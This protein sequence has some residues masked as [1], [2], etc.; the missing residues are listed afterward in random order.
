MRKC[1]CVVSL[2][3]ILM[4][5]TSALAAVPQP[6]TAA[7]APALTRGEFAA[8]LVKAAE[9]EGDGEP[10]EILVQHGIMKGVPGKG[11]D[12]LRP[13]SRV[14]A[15]A[16]VARTL[17]LADATFPPDNT[18]IPLLPDHWA[19][20][21]YAWLAR[22]G[23]VSGDPFAVLSEEEGTS[24]V[25]NTF[26]TTEDVI[27]ILQKSQAQLQAKE[28]TSFRTVMDGQIR[29]TPRPGVEGA[30][31]IPSI[32]PKLHLVQEM[33]LP[34][35]IH[36]V[37]TVQMT[38]PEIGAQEMVTESYIVDGTMYQKLPD[39]ETGELSWVKYPQA[40][41]PDMQQL[42]EQ[43]QQQTQI[44]PPGMEKSLFYKLLGTKEIDGEQVY[45]I[46]CYGKIDD[47]NEFLSAAMSNFGDSELLGEAM[48][49]A[50]SMID[51]LSFW[52]VTYVGVDDYLT[53]QANYG[54]SVT[55]AKEFQDE[56]I[57]LEKIEMLLTIK[58]YTYDENIDI[59][60]PE[61]VLSAPE[62]E[63]PEL[64][65]ESELPEESTEELAEDEAP[66]DEVPEGNASE[67]E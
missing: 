22:L 31:Q 58:E 10:S 17:G 25:E 16:L 61:E 11:D 8:M 1:L 57:P 46:A 9:L 26:Q 66:Q 54:A 30:D 44:I 23:I 67:N 39:P 24:L 41:L 34:N 48:G 52:G 29:I 15:A 33:I 38:L 13:I 51:N 42:M 32:A 59:T 45:E 37:M 62:L 40:M 63:L 35:K 50:S 4:V 5:S 53:R 18:D 6:E 49:A 47:I 21:A 19:Y 7:D 20:N 56:A 2:V 28:T 43:A 14:E 64:E 12:S 27:A 65:P 60:L 36:Q 3:L 55:Y